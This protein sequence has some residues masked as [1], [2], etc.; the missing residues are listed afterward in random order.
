[1]LLKKSESSISLLDNARQLALYIFVALLGYEYW[2]NL[3]I[4]DGMTVPKLAGLFYF[5]LAAITPKKSFAIYKHGNAL[6][7]SLLFTLWGWLLFASLLTYILYGA[8]L[9]LQMSFL[10]LIVLY[11]LI[12][13]EIS[14]D[15]NVEKNLKL[16]FVLGVFSMYILISMGVGIQSSRESEALDDLENVTRIWF[17][18]LNPNSL[19]NLAALAF[20]LALSFFESLKN[21]FVFLLIIPMLAFVELVLSSGSAGA[22]LLLCLGVGLFFVLNKPKGYMSIVYFSSGIVIVFA[23][24]NALVESE[25]LSNKLAAFFIEGETSSRTQIWIETINLTAKNPF[26]GV[27]HVYRTAHNVFL[28]MF[29]WGEW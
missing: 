18:G 23:M 8:E 19:G 26:L 4:F 22:V 21:K 12:F 6:H 27:G 7:L 14:N 3:S 11:W 10:Q 20:I 15:V 28:D 25:Y 29:K 17:M 13:N 24:L 9:S 5:A 2:N 1:M 16:A